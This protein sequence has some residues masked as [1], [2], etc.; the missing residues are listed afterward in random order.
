MSTLAKSKMT[1]SIKT[2]LVLS[3]VS[4]ISGTVHGN[5][6]DCHTRLV[7][8]PL[9][10]RATATH[11]SSNCH[12]L[13]GQLPHTTGSTAT[14]YSCNC[15]ARLVQLP[16][17]TR[18]TAT[19]NSCDCHAVLVQ[20]PRT[21]CAQLMG[22]S[23]HH[24]C[25]FPHAARMCSHMQLVGIAMHN[26]CALPR[27]GHGSL[28]GKKASLPKFPH[29]AASLTWRAPKSTP[30]CLWK[31][32]RLRSRPR[33]HAPPGSQD[34]GDDGSGGGG[35]GGGDGDDGAARIGVARGPNAARSLAPASPRSAPSS[36]PWS[37]SIG[38]AAVCLVTAAASPPPPV[39][40]VLAAAIAGG[41]SNNDNT[42]AWLWRRS[43]WRSDDWVASCV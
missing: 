22:I 10:A 27:T 24:S 16:L 3:V 35:G 7:Q 23:T 11:Y 31:S 8:L 34:G 29:R 41:G 15:H 12:T 9:A 18:A 40:A 4:I 5:T 26:S 38:H 19:L 14:H 39:A 6:T 17:S 25:A 37:G 13:L 2:R 30:Q 28:P 21:T 36:G 42:H 43:L 20:L 33:P 32:A 1:P